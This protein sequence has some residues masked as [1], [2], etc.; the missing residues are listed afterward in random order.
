MEFTNNFIPTDNVQHDGSD[1]MNRLIDDP[2][3]NRPYLD[4]YDR[5]CVTI[6]TGHRETRKDKTGDL[7][8]NEDGIPQEFPVYKTHLITN[9]QRMGVN[10][11]VWNATTLRYREWIA[12]DQMVLRATRDRLRAWS[13]LAASNTYG[14]FDG[15]SKLVLEHER[16]T[17]SGQAV[18]DMDGLSQG[19][20]DQPQFQLEG[21]PL[22]IT[23]SDFWFSNRKLAVS[24]QGNT[25]LDIAMDEMAARR[26]AET[27]EKTT[28]GMQTGTTYGD[29]TN[30]GNTAQVYGY[31]THPDRITKTNLA[32]PTDGTWVPSGTIDDVLTMIQ[33]AYAQKFYGPF[34]LYHST[35]WSQ[36]MDNDYYRTSATTGIAGNI[37]G[38]TLRDRLRQI[39]NIQDVRRLDFFTDTFS[40]LLVQM[41]SDVCRAVIGMNVNTVQW[42]ESGGEKLC[43]KVRCILVPDI[44]SVYIGPNSTTAKCGIVHGS[45]A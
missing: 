23:H 40:F 9:L 20:N 11:A 30:Y 8:T 39:E 37:V 18:V 19:Q 41:T 2:G 22:P 12:I 34:M 17:D 15:F 5:P 1:N 21:V 38:R 33:L 6:N 3:M 4:K 32:Y 27:V 31:K 16:M 24:R 13:D 29:S 25:P 44:R 7:I 26:V 28:I 42:Q 36:Y 14:G 45:T 43:F 35:D 10:K